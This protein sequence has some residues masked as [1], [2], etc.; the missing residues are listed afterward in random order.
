MLA[1]NA[2]AISASRAYHDT[3][4]SL[5]GSRATELHVLKHNWSLRRR[6]ALRPN[7]IAKHILTRLSVNKL[8][9]HTQTHQWI[10]LDETNQV[11]G[12]SSAGFRQLPRFRSGVACVCAQAVSGPRAPTG[13]RWSAQT[14]L[15][16]ICFIDRMQFSTRFILFG[17]LNW[18]FWALVLEFYYS[19]TMWGF[20]W[21][22]L[23]RYCINIQQEH[24]GEQPFMHNVSREF[25]SLHRRT[26]KCC[27]FL[28]H[29]PKIT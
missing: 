10:L 23:G 21:G 14:G 9:L 13:C 28:K 18:V 4:I 25:A 19:F 27:T 26:T 24:T 22:T 6:R 5:R 15:K 20:N 11:L 7:L 17:S 1:P 8:V 29:C 2:V 16:Q 3:A 12:N